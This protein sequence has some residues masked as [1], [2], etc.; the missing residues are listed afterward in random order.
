MKVLVI[1]N[2]MV[3][4]KFCEKLREK[5]PDSSLEIQVFGEE[6]RP[7][8]DRVHLSSYFSNSNAEDLELAPKD[9]YAENNIDLRLGELVKSIDLSRKSV[10]SHKSG[11]YSYDKL[12]IATGSYPFVP[13][14][15]GSN[16]PGV[17]V[18]RTIE[19]LEAITS[20]ALKLKQQG[21][22]NA[23]VIGGGLLGLEAAK[24]VVDLDMKAD[25]VEFAP[26]LMCRQI[27]SAGGAILKM[28]MEE[29]G[30][31]IHTSKQTSAI[32]GESGVEGLSF[33]DGTTLR[34]DMV[35][36]SAGIRPRDEV[37]RQAGLECG[38]R[39]GV[40]VDEKMTTSDPSV[41]AIG[42]VASFMGQTYGLVAPGYN[43]AEVVANQIVSGE[44]SMNEAP[45]M[46]TKLKLMGVDVA[47]FGDSIDENSK[48]IPIV[49]ENKFTKT[50][51]RINISPDGK[52]LMG[53]ILIG[54]ASQYNQFLQLY[55]NSMNLPEDPSTLLIPTQG[56]EKQD[57]VSELSDS[58]IICSCEN[59]SKGT[60]CC[61][62]KD[63]GCENLKSMA[64]TTKAGSGCGG[65]KPMVQ[66]IID[67]ELAKAGKSIKK[68]I[69]SHF[70]YTRQELLEI[71]KIKDLSD[72]EE[73]LDTVGLGHGCEICKPVVAS[74][75]ASLYSETANKQPV[76]QDSNDRFLANIQRNGT[77]SVVP[78][79]PGGEITP[80]KLIVIGE[81]AQKYN[82]Y[83]KITGGQRIDLFGA[84]LNDLPYIWEEL[85]RAG[86][87]SGHAY[88]KA[89]RTVKSCVGST[90]CRYGMN[91]AVSLA[92]T[93]EER[94][95]GIRSPHKLKGGVSGC[96]RECAEARGKD[97][98]IIAVEGG[99]NLYICG[100][101]GAKPVHAVLLASG[102]DETTC[103]KYLDRFL[104]Y[105]IKTAEPLMRT[106][107]WLEKLDGGIDFLRSVV[108][109]DVL[110]LGEQLEAEMED[111]KNSYKCE[112]KEAIENP[113][114][115]SRFKHFFNSDSQDETLEFVSLRDQKMP[116][117]W[118]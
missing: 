81:V 110:N 56:S 68:I 47:S 49:I 23:V 13:P 66:S 53:G 17:F 84:T 106:S 108:V 116:V 86:F 59:I 19:D 1:G 76:I 63:Q 30:V 102:L 16:L 41:F 105:Y 55:K 46:S 69:C 113:A 79:I 37:A 39:G 44:G 88:G 57:L 85:I 52:K 92:I 95:K 6:L 4:Y 29:L 28:K 50:Y 21:K 45:D 3:G 42:E 109:D 61:A 80:E 24:A 75:F 103:I 2:G 78:R 118:S 48:Y 101:G 5:H 15:P 96:I 67:G 73:A 100:N 74:I 65:C 93:I 36:V 111:L 33:A 58:A 8:Y 82:L 34:T 60:I 22:R 9:W 98:G 14:I 27:D 31:M 43:M 99:L 7:A 77:Y 38:I 25:V 104:M 54:D 72:F 18:Y 35:I 112:W 83:T 107:T 94:Y 97:F 89:L 20:Y 26:H 40:K 64:K 115:R 87:E 117:R 91:E 32:I 114:I 71:I 70:Q 11:F 90:W 12:V 62:V 51:K 10:E